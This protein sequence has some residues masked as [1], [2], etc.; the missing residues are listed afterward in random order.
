MQKSIKTVVLA[1]LCIGW[2]GSANAAVPVMDLQAISTL[3]NQLTQVKMQV[4]MM[5][6]NLVNLG[7][8]NWNDINNAAGQLAQS[9]NAMSSLSYAAQN[10][11]SQFQQT[12]TGY[13]AGADY[14]SQYQQITRTTLNTVQGSL[15][16]MNMSYSQFQSDSL[17]LKA[18]Q[19]Q[20]E[21]ADGALKAIQVNAQIGSEIAQQVSSLRSVMM[22]Q[23]SSEQTYVA[24]QTQL[25]AQRKANKDAMIN[26][27]LTAIPAY[28]TYPADVNF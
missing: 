1:S 4:D 24:Q 12:Y 13:K 21:G 18:M 6:Q 17:R 15:N 9:M 27:G 8:Y 2:L 16:A 28:G 26:N 25:E 10:I 14:S 23:A 22:A 20:A 3:A 11:D 19:S 5:K 7:Q